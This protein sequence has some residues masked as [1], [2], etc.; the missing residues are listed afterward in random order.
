MAMN[1]D[2]L[3]ASIQNI[4][5]VIGGINNQLGELIPRMN[6]QIEASNALAT[7][8]DAKLKEAVNPMIEADLITGM[9]RV[10]DMQTTL[11]AMTTDCD[12]RLKEVVNAV[13]KLTIGANDQADSMNA[14]KTYT[15]GANDRV[16][17]FMQDVNKIEQ[18]I[19]DETNKQEL[20]YSQQQAQMAT[21]SSTQGSA[22]KR[23]GRE[24]MSPL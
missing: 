8:L 4:E 9:R 20:R 7:T 5:A 18:A 1:N 15:T 2:Q 13:D 23:R 10:N 21:L 16:D 14:M 22:P 24:A 3:T 12:K 6:T 19:K 11:H 17:A